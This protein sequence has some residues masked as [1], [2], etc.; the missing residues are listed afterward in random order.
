[1]KSKQLMF[2]ALKDDIKKVLIELESNIQVQ[3]CKSGMFDGKNMFKYYYH[4]EIPNLGYTPYG[5]WNRIDE[6]LL[7]KK[8]TIINLE[9][10]PQRAGGFKYAVDQGCNMKSIEIKLG[11]VF[12]EEE[13]VLVAGRVAT[14]S[15]EADSLELYKFLSTKIKRD[16]KRIGAFYVGKKAEERLNEGWRL[17]T[18]VRLSKEF[19]LVAK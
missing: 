5:D 2:F 11:G 17:V 1:M 12:T 3:Y 9:L 19:D 8:A 13:N 16:F 7:C 4:F 10:V 15:E 6:Y 18:N 14:I